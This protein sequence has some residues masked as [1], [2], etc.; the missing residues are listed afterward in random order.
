MEGPTHS[1]AGGRARLALRLSL[2]YF[3][4]S[5]ALLVWPLYPALGNAIEPRILGLPWSLVYVL[6]VIIANAATLMILY[7]GR[8]I[9]AGEVDD[10]DSEAPR[11]ADEV[12]G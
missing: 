12:R 1:R 9:D 6:A 8:W 3:A 4:V 11:A 5:T 2:A 7:V 10:A